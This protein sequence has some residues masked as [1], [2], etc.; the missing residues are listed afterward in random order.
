MNNTVEIQT[1]RNDDLYKD[2]VPYNLVEGNHKFGLRL[3]LNPH[4]ISYLVRD[5]FSSMYNGKLTLMEINLLKEKMDK[6]KIELDKYRDEVWDDTFNLRKTIREQCVLCQA[7]PTCSEK[8]D[9]HL[10]EC[11]S[12]YK[13]T[14]SFVAYECQFKENGRCSHYYEIK[15]LEENLENYD[16]VME[17][18]HSDHI[19][20]EITYERALAI[21][22][23]RYEEY[24]RKIEED[25]EDWNFEV[26]QRMS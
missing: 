17:S 13:C 12:T 26:S 6:A 22:E 16:Y 3:R 23:D 21:K 8:L 2:V 24:K 1:M 18:C 5:R 19:D 25:Y 15:H 4:P 10:K 11:N 7:D 20:L 14:K 9:K